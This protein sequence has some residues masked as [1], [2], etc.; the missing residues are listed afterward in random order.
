M[1]HRFHDDIARGVLIARKAAASGRLDHP[2]ALTRFLYQNW[3][4][5]RPNRSSP[6]LPQMPAQRE[7]TPAPEP[8]RTWGSRWPERSCRGDELVR[9]LLSC[10]PRTSLH[11]LAATTAHADT[12]DV[13][14]LLSSRALTQPSADA[15]VL[16]LPVDALDEL[17]EPIRAL[18]H[19]VQPFLVGTTPAL[20]LRIG[21]G[22]AL[23]QNPGDGRGYGEHRCS[24]LAGTVLTHPNHNHR[25]LVERTL[26]ALRRAG[27]DPQ[28]PYRALGATWGWSTRRALAA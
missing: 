24:L 10:A 21:R 12:W 26:S 9:L 2:A 25:Q 13:P 6:A 3:Y 8:W 7:G 4:L 14:W 28:Q 19:D 15:T 17:Q 11:V 5:A 23:A 27:V 16:Y 22:A 18:L 20:T 1:S